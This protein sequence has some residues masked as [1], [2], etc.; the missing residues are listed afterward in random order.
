MNYRLQLSPISNL[1]QPHPLLGVDIKRTTTRWEE[2]KFFRSWLVYD[3]DLETS[4]SGGRVNWS[5][6][7]GLVVMAAV[8]AGG[9][10]GV[11]LVLRHL[12]K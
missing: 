10:Y 4:R 9:W 6:I 1:P 12:L 5:V 11:S 3:S 2:M 7:V 8:S